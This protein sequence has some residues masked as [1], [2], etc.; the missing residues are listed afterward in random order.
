MALGSSARTSAVTNSDLRPR[1][2]SM[3]TPRRTTACSSRQ[4]RA[5]IGS[6]NLRSVALRKTTADVSVKATSSGAPL[7]PRTA[8]VYHPVRGPSAPRAAASHLHGRTS[9]IHAAHR[10][11]EFGSIALRADPAI[12]AFVVRH[13]GVIAGIRRRLG[14]LPHVS[15]ARCCRSRRSRL[16]TRAP[17]TPKPGASTGAWATCRSRCSRCCGGQSCPCCSW[18]SAWDARRVRPDTSLHPTRCGQPRKPGLQ[19][20]SYPCSPGL[21]RSPAHY[22]HNS[23]PRE[24]HKV[25]CLIGKLKCV[26][27]QRDAL[28][29]ILIEGV[30]G[31]PGCL[32]YVVAN[33]TP[34]PFARAQPQLKP[35]DA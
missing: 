21:H 34:S 9:G 33:S 16:L 27:G 5:T 2:V 4:S 23:S 29:A 30:A 22:D 1:R 25:H 13:R 31:M 24:A 6:P 12:T 3:S 26:P 18:S 35:Q 8:A 32:S 20:A 7:G 10:P 28:P 11:I 15:R 14:A 19:H 17:S